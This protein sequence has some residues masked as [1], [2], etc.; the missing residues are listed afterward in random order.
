MYI[1]GVVSS[2]QDLIELLQ[3]QVAHQWQH[4]VQ[5]RDRQGYNPDIIACG[6]APTY[7]DGV[8]LRATA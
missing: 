3:W 8:T 7:S 6:E 4:S 1:I 5:Y 2:P